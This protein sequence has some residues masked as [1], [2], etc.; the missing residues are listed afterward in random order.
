MKKGVLVFCGA[1]SVVGL[2]VFG[3]L[4]KA[5]SGQEPK[6]AM[7]CQANHFVYSIDYL[8]NKGS[9]NEFFY[10]VDTRFQAFMS[11]T[12]LAEMKLVTDFDD[13]IDVNQIVEVEST[14][15]TILND[16]YEDVAQ[17]F[18][19]SNKLT[20]EQM[21]LIASAAHSTD[22]RIRMDYF[23]NNEFYEK[24]QRNYTS[25][26]FT[27]IP[28]KQAVY[29]DGKEGLLTYLKKDSQSVIGNLDNEQ[30][31]PGK[32]RFTVTKKGTVKDVLLIS[33]SGYQTIDDRMVELIKTMP[34]L[35]QPAEDVNGKKVDEQLVFS[36]GI[37]GC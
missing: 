10:D 3:G 4:S 36:F 16:K 9:E 21:E 28:E 29:S 25:P 6:E 2:M 19:K 20:A 22:I 23:E 27:V 30:L 26:H 7:P 17:A 14:S 5:D 37:V 32:V 12:K 33:T 11:K 15:V 34:G 8:L 13:R 35:W 1:A 24:P 18:G 31:Q